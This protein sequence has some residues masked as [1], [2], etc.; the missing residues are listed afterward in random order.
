MIQ[1]EGVR[2]R[3]RYVTY[4]E[5]ILGIEQDTQYPWAASKGRKVEVC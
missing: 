5:A 4:R 2:M 1:R 3:P